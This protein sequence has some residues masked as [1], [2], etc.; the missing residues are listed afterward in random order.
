MEEKSIINDRCGEV[1]ARGAPHGWKMC[2]HIFMFKIIEMSIVRC[3][4]PVHSVLICNI[5]NHLT[6]MTYQAQAIAF[7]NLS[8]R[9]LS[10]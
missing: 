8:Q 2:L 7:A 4:D 6:S 10:I 1:R 3:R 9:D 5:C